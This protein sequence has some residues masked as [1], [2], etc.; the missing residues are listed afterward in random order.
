[1]QSPC[2]LRIVRSWTAVGMVAV[3]TPPKMG[4]DASAQEL[5]PTRVLAGDRRR[6]DGAGRGGV[7]LQAGI[8]PGQ[9]HRCAQSLDG[10]EGRADASLAGSTAGHRGPPWTAIPRPS[11][12]PHA[13]APVSPYSWAR[14][15]PS[16]L[17]CC[18]SPMIKPSQLAR[19]AAE[20]AGAPSQLKSWRSFSTSLSMLTRSWAIESRSRTV[21]V[22]SASVSE[23]T[24]TPYGVPISSCRR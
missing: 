15:R 7:H 6:R 3:A 11:V 19:P 9:E 10:R 1:L 20:H 2:A 5:F 21:T 23:S 16:C 17:S 14:A 13:A 12:R 8:P 4:T 22:L 18:C 24:V